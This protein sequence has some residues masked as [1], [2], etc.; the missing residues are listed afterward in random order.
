MMELPPVESCRTG[1][2]KNSLKTQARGSRGTLCERGGVTGRMQDGATESEGLEFS[3]PGGET[4]REDSELER[5][6]DGCSLP[7]MCTTGIAG[8]S[9]LD[10]RIGNSSHTADSEKREQLVNVGKKVSRGGRGRG[11]GRGRGGKAD[12]DTEGINDSIENYSGRGRRGRARG[13][14]SNAKGADFEE[15]NDSIGNNSGRGRRGRARGRGR[16]SKTGGVVAEETNELIHNDSSRERRGRGK[17]RGRVRET[18][19]PGCDVELLSCASKHGGEDISAQQSNPFGDERDYSLNAV[20]PVTEALNSMTE[21]PRMR[22]QILRIRGGNYKPPGKRGREKDLNWGTEG[23]QAACSS[24]TEESDSDLSGCLLEAGPNSSRDGQDRMNIEGHSTEAKE[25]DLKTAG[26]TIRK[27]HG[28]GKRSLLALE[29]EKGDRVRNMSPVMEEMIRIWLSEIKIHSD[30]SLFAQLA[31]TSPELRLKLDG[32]NVSSQ[33]YAPTLKLPLFKS[34]KIAASGPAQEDSPRSCKD[35]LLHIGGPVWALDWCPQRPGWMYTGANKK[36]F[37]AVAAHPVSAPYNKMGTCLNGKGLIQIWALDLKDY[38]SEDEENMS[39]GKS[40]NGK[41]TRGRSA[42]SGKVAGRGVGRGRGRGK[43]KKPVGGFIVDL[44][45]RYQDAGTLEPLVLKWHEDWPEEQPLAQMVLGLTHEG[46]VTWDAKWQPVGEEKIALQER[47]SLRLGFLAAVL[48]NGSLQ[49]YDVPMPSIFS[50]TTVSSCEEPLIVSIEP[51]F[52]CSSLQKRGYKSIPVSLEWSTWDPHDRLLVGFHDASVGVWKFVPDFPATETRPLMFFQADALPLRSVAWA[53]EGS[54]PQ[55][56][57]LIVTAGHSGWVKFWDLRDIFRPIWDL[58][59]SRC[60]ISSMD[61]LSHPRSLLMSMDDGTLRLLGIQN[62]SSLTP[63]TGQPWRGTHAQG[64]QCYLCSSFAIWSVQVS[65][66]T[67]LVAYGGANGSVLQFQLT[68]KAV[69]KEGARAR[70]PHFLCGAFEANSEDGPLTLLSAKTSEPVQM[71]KSSTEWSSTPTSKR[72]F[73]A[74][75]S[76]DPESGDVGQVGSNSE[77]ALV[78]KPK[79]AKG[80]AATGTICQ[81]NR[82]RDAQMNSLRR[83]SDSTELVVANISNSERGGEQSAPQADVHSIPTGPLSG[84]RFPCR[85][86]AVHR[87]RWNCNYPKRQ[88]LA[89]G[90]AAGLVRCQQVY[91]LLKKK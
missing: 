53:P 79:R 2:K 72:N 62:A 75:C 71:K 61:W 82:H 14:G 85:N 17:G 27:T 4:A 44:T 64:L 84:E 49:V 19:E 30:W 56:R 8:P 48:G 65:R 34:A 57:H 31:A 21:L 26:D 80:I 39:S 87:V 50:K 83:N 38:D 69:L 55:G 24:A 89:Y 16:G 36:E 32:S 13:R 51:V 29:F 58:Q 90:G 10:V 63:A 41:S 60:C 9:Q 88:W 25:A 11:K 5:F 46:L 45:A 23:Y 59:T 7:L 42:G 66:A 68:E 18:T 76:L 40:R 1:E 22:S 35:I 20:A 12:G 37:L 86:I 15:T 81:V 91:S 6:E 54:G 3:E 33:D 43:V 73:L 67:G 28:A 74:S 77:N 70:E 52:K 78:P 47:E